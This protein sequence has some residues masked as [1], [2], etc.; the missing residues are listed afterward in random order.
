V[1]SIPQPEGRRGP[2][3]KEVAEAA[4]VSRATASRVFTDSPRVSHQARRAVEHA[5]RRLGYVPNRAARSL[6]TGRTGS[7][8]LVIPEPTPRLFGDPHFAR[9]VRG[10]SEG[11]S[12]EDLQLVLL[13][14]QSAADEQRLERYL[15][16][17]HVDGALLISLHGHDPLPARL[18]ERRL[19]VVIG[20]RPP[21]EGSVSH[22][23]VDNVGGA[24]AAVRHLAEQGRRTIATITGPLDMPAAQDRL[25][26]YRTALQQAGL[27]GGEGLEEPGDFS[28]EGGIQAMRTLLERRMD[29]DAVFAASDLMAA[30]ALQVL[31]ETGR[32][33][34]D[35]VAMVGFDDSPFAASTVPP[36]SSVRQPIEEWGREMTRLL[37]SEI[38][39]DR[40]V[41]RRVVLA[42]ELVVRESSVTSSGT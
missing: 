19:P 10:I 16:A 17:G 42:T 38:E 23:D 24:R 33:V 2:T 6:R 31:R 14:P 40:P 11:L 35:D 25:E 30:G 28:H 26:G 29:L 8:A 34:P 18:V 7:V 15:A 1:E 36:L 27:A 20:G 13:V 3:L 39:S 12:A 4:G 21:V 32:G 37:L 5:A 9:V 41:V 22:V